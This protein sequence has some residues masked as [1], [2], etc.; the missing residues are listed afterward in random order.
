MIVLILWHFDWNGTAER[1]REYDEV[2]KKMA[3]KTEGVEFLG[4]YVPWNNRYQWTYI[5]KSKDR[6]TWQEMG[7]NFEWDSES[8]GKLAIEETCGEYELYGGP[9][10]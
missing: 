4:R 10:E 6:K 5:V 3:E 9:R 2:H 7:K 1:L 8:M